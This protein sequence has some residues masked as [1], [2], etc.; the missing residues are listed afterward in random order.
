MGESNP[1]TSLTHHHIETITLTAANLFFIEGR[2]HLVTGQSSMLKVMVLSMTHR[3]R[4]SEFPIWDD[5]HRA[6]KGKSTSSTLENEVKK[7][8]HVCVE[9]MNTVL[10][11]QGLV[12]SV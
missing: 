7:E 9:Y 10:T 1:K 5:L 8:R 6:V 4:V 12:V 3:R 11:I 2:S